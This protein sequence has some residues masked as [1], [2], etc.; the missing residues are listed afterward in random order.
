MEY[1][2]ND[3]GERTKVVLDIEEYD[4]LVWTAQNAAEWFEERYDR[5]P[6]DLPKAVTDSIKREREAGSQRRPES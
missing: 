6:D 3:R 1:I 5:L 4:N 2:I